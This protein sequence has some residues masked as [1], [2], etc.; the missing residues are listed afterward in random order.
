M[1]RFARF[2]DEEIARYLAKLVEQG[3]TDTFRMA[4]LQNTPQLLQ[5]MGFSIRASSALLA[6]LR[7]IEMFKV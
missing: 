1:L 5:V 7:E 3:F 2:T 6:V 4:T